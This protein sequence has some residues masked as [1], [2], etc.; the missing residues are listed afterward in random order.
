MWILCCKCHSVTH[1]HL[2]AG[3]LRLFLKKQEHRLRWFFFRALWPQAGRHRRESTH[4]LFKQPVFIEN[5]EQLS[6]PSSY[7][8]MK[9]GTSG[10][11]RGSLRREEVAQMVDRA[12]LTHKGSTPNPTWTGHGGTGL[13]IPELGKTRGPE[14]QGHP[15]LR[16]EFKASLG[17][18]R[19]YCLK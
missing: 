12:G 13:L 6:F 11:L 19:T 7:D 4:L 2:T 5:G 16:S 15:W 17:Y 3:N 1:S 14:V 8:V 18:L 10:G 9:H